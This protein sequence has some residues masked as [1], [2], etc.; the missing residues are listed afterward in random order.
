MEL[1]SV[2]IGL[3]NKNK[4][5]FKEK[6]FIKIVRSEIYNPDFQYLYKKADIE[7]GILAF[8][9][10]VLKKDIK[11]A[12]YSDGIAEVYLLETDAKINNEKLKMEL[13][14][15]IKN[16]ITVCTSK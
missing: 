2:I 1:N 15:R 11:L 7:R 9:V 12:V 10:F 16:S 13:Y 8:E 5:L 6:D 14:N 4:F 3:M